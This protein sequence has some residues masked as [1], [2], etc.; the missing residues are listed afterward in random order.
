MMENTAPKS[1]WCWAM[2]K[3][4]QDLNFNYNEKIKTSPYHFV[5]GQHID[6]KYSIFIV[7]L[8]SVTCSSLS[9]IVKGSYR[10]GE[11]NDA[12]FLHIPT[13]RS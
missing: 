4:S 1:M 12:N 13:R 6:M 8:Q 3:A 5:T 7:F 9:R 11:L 2:F 10:I